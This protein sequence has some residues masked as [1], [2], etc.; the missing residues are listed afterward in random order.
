MGGTVAAASAVTARVT[1]DV[2][3]FGTAG[4]G[5]ADDAAAIQSALDDAAAK[6]GGTVFLPQ[7]AV[8]Y[9]ITCGLKIPSHVTLEG[10]APVR[11]PFNA[12]NTGACALVADFADARQWMIEPATRA[13]GRAISPDRLVNGQLPD[14]VTYNC[15]V[16]NLL[17]T[18]TGAVPF[19]GI[20]FHGCPGAFAEGV[21]IDRVGCGLLVNYSFGGTF[22]VH[23]QALYY[24]VVA[25]DE[26]NANSFE[27][28]CARNAD[29][30]ARVPA[31]Y[32]LPF[33]AQM[34]GRFADTLKLS[35]ED[36]LTRPYGL[37]CG[38]TRSTSVGNVFDVVIERFPGGIFLCNAYATDFR[39]CYMEAGA[40]QIE[41]GI[42]ATRS[43]FGVQAL[44][45]Y[46]SGTGALFDFGTEVLAKIFA[47]GI[48]Y[49]RTFGKPPEADGTSVLLLEGVEIADAP[50]AAGIRY[51]GKPAAW[52]PLQ[53]APGWTAGGGG[54]PVA[55][56]RL[57]PWSHRVEFR[58][59]VAGGKGHCA[60]LPMPCRPPA[61][62]RFLVPGGT[63]TI[64]ADGVMDAVADD[65]AI[66]LD[67]I[68]FSRW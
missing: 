22:T 51:A 15:G 68:A 65:G 52:V 30:P 5:V 48:L 20:R 62:S 32:A 56:V 28:Y 23:V 6:G 8:H 34:R 44:H 12:G 26:A 25:W 39:R 9:R 59:E 36:H 58:G 3:A 35:D 4:D 21:A 33:M 7:P 54:Q 47:S 45:A 10:T 57:D 41:C 42:T 60:T 19:G 14:G 46:F 17:L 50:L 49:A 1:V 38:A 27:I 31:G 63:V 2:T 24:G 18:S 37:V 55:A 66:A 16:R 40:G 43:R 53:L 67:G 61:R 13:Q 64:G 29:A 11:Y